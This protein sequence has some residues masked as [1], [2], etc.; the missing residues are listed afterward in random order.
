M[1]MIA[2]VILV[3]LMSWGTKRREEPAA[4]AAGWGEPANH[5]HD[6]RDVAPIPRRAPRTVPFA[7]DGVQDEFA[8]MQTLDFLEPE[9][10]A[11]TPDNDRVWILCH[12][13]A[14]V[15]IDGVYCGEAPRPQPFLLAPGFHTL[16]LVARASPTALRLQASFD[17]DKSYVIKVFLDS[18][19]A[20]MNEGAF[21]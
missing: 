21:P 16:E 20:T 4:W 11:P 3:A 14:D 9:P 12:P 17:P 8:S 19:E 5:L 18:G 6:V 7:G 1:A 10:F 2:G 13:V 15:Y